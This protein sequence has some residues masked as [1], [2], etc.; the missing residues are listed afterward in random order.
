MSDHPDASRGPRISLLSVAFLITATLLGCFQ[1]P[2]HA[3]PPVEVQNVRVGFGQANT[4]KIGAWT[5]VWVQLGAGPERFSG[6]MDLV[7]PDDDGIP[8][9]YRQT[10]ELGPRQIQ[11]LTAYGRPGGRDTEF[12]IRLFRQPGHA[13]ARGASGDQ[14]A[15][16]AE[17]DHARRKADPDARSAHGR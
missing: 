11:R 1:V 8:T 17:I 3:A 12:T 13:R 10:V 6:F 5:P 4:F 14:H 15:R 2:T 9:S 7:V 16:A